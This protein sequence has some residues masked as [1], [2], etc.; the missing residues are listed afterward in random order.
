MRGDSR[1]TPERGSLRG[2]SEDRTRVDA[3][4]AAFRRDLEV[5]GLADADLLLDTKLWQRSRLAGA[6][7]AEDLAAF[8]A[9]M[10]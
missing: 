7:V 6:F 9:V 8:S 3:V 4:T 1:W 5:A 2:V 10:L